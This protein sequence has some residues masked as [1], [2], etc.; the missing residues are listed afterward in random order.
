MAVTTAQSTARPFRPRPSVRGLIDFL[1]EADARR[2]ARA[3]FERL[4]DH[5]LR[6]IGLTRTDRDAALMRGDLL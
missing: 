5:L 3:Q 1:V 4:D 2:R 6:D